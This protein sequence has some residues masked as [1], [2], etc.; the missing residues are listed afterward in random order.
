M[1]LHLLTV[2]NK[3]LSKCTNCNCLYYRGKPPVIPDEVA[4]EVS[5]ELFSLI[6][7]ANVDKNVTDKNMNQ[8]AY[9]YH[10]KKAIAIIKYFSSS[11]LIFHKALHYLDKIFFSGNVEIEHQ[12]NLIIICVICVILSYKYNAAQSENKLKELL[13][14]IRVQ[15][16]FRVQYSNLEKKCVQLLN[17]QL[18]ELTTYEYINFFF[19]NGLFFM[20][21]NALF[22]DINSL[23]NQAISFLDIFI[24]DDRYLDFEPYTLSICIIMFLFENC[25]FFDKRIFRDIYNVNFKDVK[26][27]KCSFVLRTL[28]GKNFLY[29]ISPYNDGSNC[30]S[31]N[32]S[33]STVD[34]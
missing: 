10:R 24:E 6:N 4:N 17:Y 21:N 9:L 8:I 15:D 23:Y 22:L 25:I 5:S 1:C 16:N 26:Y 18:G 12:Q 30:S 14:S 28:F 33:S 13:K 19:A 29:R 2:I 11:K 3:N 27:V 31:K 7:E 32:S 34:L 20:S